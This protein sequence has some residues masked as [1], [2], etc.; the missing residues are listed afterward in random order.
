MQ[1]TGYFRTQTVLLFQRSS[2]QLFAKVPFIEKPGTLT[3]YPD[4]VPTSE[5]YPLFTINEPASK[6]IF[7]CMYLIIRSLLI[8]RK[9][10][11]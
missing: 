3:E 6:N 2:V 1:L 11:N 5:L 4:T 10:C 8:S 9:A 7:K